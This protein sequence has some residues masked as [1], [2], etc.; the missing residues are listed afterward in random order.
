MALDFTLFGGSVKS[1]AVSKELRN[2]VLA[3]V[4]ESVAPFLARRKEA[5][6]SQG[7]YFSS[8]PSFKSP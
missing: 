7:I 6:L 8:T 5:L 2:E 3:F 1:F 4:V